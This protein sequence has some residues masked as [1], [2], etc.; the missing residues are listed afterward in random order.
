[1][2][3][4]SDPDDLPPRKEKIFDTVFNGLFPSGQFFH[5]LHPVVA[6]QL[7]KDLRFQRCARKAMVSRVADVAVNEIVSHLLAGHIIVIRQAAARRIVHTI[8]DKACKQIQFQAPD[9]LSFSLVQDG[10]AL[11][12][13]PSQRDSIGSPLITALQMPSSDFC[14]HF[15]FPPLNS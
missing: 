3:F 1:M 15:V 7:L 10:K 13:A 9:K 11:P 14:C 12:A 6:R 2:F 5:F 8:I 4:D